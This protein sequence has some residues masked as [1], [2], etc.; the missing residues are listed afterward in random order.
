MR[1][2]GGSRFRIVR[3]ELVSRADDDQPGGLSVQ[4]ADAQFT[5]VDDAFRVVS[6]EGD[7]SFSEAF[8]PGGA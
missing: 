6:L 1:R 2:K 8:G 5:E 7:G 4:L 3:F